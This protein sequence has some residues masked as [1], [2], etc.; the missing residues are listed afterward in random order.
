MKGSKVIVAVNKGP[1]APVFQIADYGLVGALFTVLPECRRRSRRGS[2]PAG[3][4]AVRA[5]VA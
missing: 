1:D 3:N 5:L 2:G 4:S